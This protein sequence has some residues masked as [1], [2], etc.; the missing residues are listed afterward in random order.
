[1]LDIST[2]E[3]AFPYHGMGLSTKQE[4]IRRNP[5]I[6]RSVMKAYVEGIKIYKTDRE[7][8]AKVRA[9]YT[10]RSDMDELRE[11]W[12]MYV[13]V[14]P[15]APYPAIDGIK[16]MLADLNTTFPDAR[17]IDIDRFY[18]DS[19]VRDLEVSGF[20]SNLYKPETK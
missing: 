19:F 8:T 10:R 3:F 7:F 13:N 16:T 20:I 9:K 18:D 2:T 11:E 1:M 6:V 4:I 5:D 15:K 14:V 12:R 17:K